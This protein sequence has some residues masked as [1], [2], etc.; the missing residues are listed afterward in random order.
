MLCFELDMDDRELSLQSLGL[1]VPQGFFGHG[2]G[3]A[4]TEV[5]DLDGSAGFRVLYGQVPVGDAP[6]YGVAV[7]RA[8][9]VADDGIVGEDWFLAHHN[10]VGKI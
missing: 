8:G 9:H 6:V 4:L 5:I 3:I 10:G 7:V 2:S 1:R